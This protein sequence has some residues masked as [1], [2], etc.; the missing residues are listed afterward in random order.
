MPQTTLFKQ[1]LLFRLSS[2][3]K[4]TFKKVQMRALTKR[5]P[6]KL[7]KFKLISLWLNVWFIANGGYELGFIFN[8]IYIVKYV[9]NA[10]C[11][12]KLDK[13]EI[14]TKMEF[15]KDIKLLMIREIIVLIWMV[16]VQTGLLVF[17]RNILC[18]F[19]LITFAERNSPRRVAPPSKHFNY[20]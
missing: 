18:F 12:K 2:S 6:S 13:T 20:A 16:E 14:D 15:A 10:E 7:F 9:I 3:S 19:D 1:N 8:A 11:R 5:A 4:L 17:P